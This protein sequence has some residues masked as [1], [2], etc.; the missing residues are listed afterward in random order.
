MY[1]ERRSIRQRLRDIVRYG[2]GNVSQDVRLTEYMSR[3]N[4]GIAVVAGIACAALELVL[5]FGALARAA[6]SLS[7]GKL[8]SYLLLGMASLVLSYGS[9]RYLKRGGSPHRYV[10]FLASFLCLAAAYGMHNSLVDLA[11]GKQIITFMMVMMLITCVFATPPIGILLITTSSYVCFY[12]LGIKGGG[13]DAGST[14]NFCLSWVVTNVAGFLRYRECL[15]GAY[16]E[17]RLRKAGEHDGLTALRN[18]VA[19]REDLPKLCG[20]DQYV[21]MVDLDD[22]KDVNDCYGHEA[23]DDV[24]RACGKALP[25]TF[26][27]ALIY[28]YGGDEFLLVVPADSVENMD[29]CIRELRG[30]VREVAVSDGNTIEVG[31]SVGVARGKPQD[32]NDLRALMRTADQALYEDKHARKAGR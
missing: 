29:E 14:V 11:Q 27:F 10:V 2:L 31:M 5:V 8:V 22:F 17:S 4:A 21:L 19:L 9:Y 6:D 15:Q 28:R 7:V 18:R 16:N 23:G 30:R 20:R 13:M 25:A 12:L 1:S 26:P 32:A 3:L 24:L